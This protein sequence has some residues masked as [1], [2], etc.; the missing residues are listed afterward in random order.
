VAGGLARGLAHHTDC[1]GQYT[2]LDYQA[3]L[4]AHSL[5]CSISRAGDCLDNAVAERFF[6]T[7]KVELIDVRTWPPRA[8]ARLAIFAWIEVWYNRQW[9]HSALDYRAPVAWECKTPPPSATLSAE[10]GQLQVTTF[11]DLDRAQQA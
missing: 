11:L 5:T 7:L 6:A 9:H 1:G 3:R 10:M 8:A 4:A 2:A